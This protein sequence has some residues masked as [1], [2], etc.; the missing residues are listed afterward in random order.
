MVTLIRSTTRLKSSSDTSAVKLQQEGSMK[1]MYPFMLSIS[2]ASWIVMPSSGGF[3]ARKSS[4]FAYLP[5]QA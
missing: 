3:L 2:S 5:R 1:D 4:Y